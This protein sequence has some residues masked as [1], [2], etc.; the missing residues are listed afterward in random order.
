MAAPTIPGLTDHEMP[1]ILTAAKEAGAKWAGFVVLRLPHAVAPLFETW[2]EEHFPDRK[3]KVLNR[4]RDLRGGKLYDAQWGVR[5][6]GTGVFADQIEALFEITCRRLGLNEE[7]R[8][9]STAAFRRRS[10]Q[11]SLF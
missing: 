10:D 6:R 1:S 7:H 5:G 2:L 8:E 9:L 4:M 3:E 11:G